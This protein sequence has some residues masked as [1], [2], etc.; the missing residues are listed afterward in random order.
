MKAQADIAQ[1]TVSAA[2]ND[3]FK[4]ASALPGP[5]AYQSGSP[6]VACQ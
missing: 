1:T 6:P 5:I 3:R 4:S 2:N